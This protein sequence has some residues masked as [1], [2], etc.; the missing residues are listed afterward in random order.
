MIRVFFIAF[1]FQ[2]IGCTSQKLYSGVIYIYNPC[3]YVLEIMTFNDG[4]YLVPNGENIN[5]NPGERKP[6]I[7]ADLSRRD[8]NFYDFFSDDKDF[9]IRILGGGKE[10]KFTG[11]H[12]ISLSKNISSIRDW[13]GDYVIYEVNNITICPAK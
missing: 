12:F 9:K 6:W 1:I 5:L 13:K 10:M 7:M 11:G 3:D 2:L 4:G 8:Q